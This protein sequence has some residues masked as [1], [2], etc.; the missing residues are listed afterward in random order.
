MGW[1]EI[2]VTSETGK[3]VYYST[4]ATDI[5]ITK[6]NIAELAECARSRWTVENSVFRELK[7]FFHLHNFGPRPRPACWR[8]STWLPS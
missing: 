5:T 3:Q 2:T 6:D 7:K 4:F 1:F 8:C